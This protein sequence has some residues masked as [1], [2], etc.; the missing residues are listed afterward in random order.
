MTPRQLFFTKGAGRHRAKSVSFE[1]ALREA[2]IAQYNLVEVTSIFP[3]G[4]KIIPSEEGIIHLS[5]GEIVFCVMSRNSTNEPHRVMASSIGLA[6]PAEKDKYGYL[7]EHQS[8][9]EEAEA[10]GEYAESL[11]VEMLATKLTEESD[12]IAET[13]NITQ[14]ASSEGNGLWT[15]TVAVAVFVPGDN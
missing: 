8:F 2:G 1:M 3:P 4:C 6:V 12:G 10:A 7:L 13:L 9:D 11:A 5:P 15:T 14:T